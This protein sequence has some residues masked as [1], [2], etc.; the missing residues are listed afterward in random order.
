MGRRAHEETKRYVH[1]DEIGTWWRRAVASVLA[2]V[3]TMAMAGTAH[4]VESPTPGA[5]VESATYGEP[6]AP[7][8]QRLPDR[9]PFTM[10]APYNTTGVRL[11]N[12]DDRGDGDCVNYIGYS[13]WRNT[14]N[15]VGSDTMQNFLSLDR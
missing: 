1:R 14:N 13:Y 3:S 9:G 15:L 11:T 8:K 6:R 7:T 5:L 2:T 12:A 10:P 4:A